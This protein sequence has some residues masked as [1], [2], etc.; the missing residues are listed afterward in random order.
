MQRKPP[1]LSSGANDR[2]QRTAAALEL[3]IA[4]GAALSTIVLKE[5]FTRPIDT[6]CEPTTTSTVPPRSGPDHGETARTDTKSTSNST[7]HDVYSC[8]FVLASTMTRPAR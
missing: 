7:P 4:I 2:R 3:L 6:V 1:K 8:P 5:Q